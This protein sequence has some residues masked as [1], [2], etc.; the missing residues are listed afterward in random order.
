MLKAEGVKMGHEALSGLV[1]NAM[2]TLGRW[3]PEGPPRQVNPE[4]VKQ[5]AEILATGRWGAGDARLDPDPTGPYRLPDIQF[6][7]LIVDLKEVSHPARRQLNIAV[8]GLRHAQTATE[9]RAAARE[10][11]AALAELIACLLRFLVR[12]LLRLLSGALARTRTADVPTWQ[13]EPIEESP[14]ITPR[15]P[16]SFFPVCTYRGGRRGSA[17]GSAVLAA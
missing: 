14:Q 3:A 10:F 8:D 2:A 15:G 9:R 1:S 11:L 12:A 16:N 4:R 13:P 6:G 7:N 17:L 5:F